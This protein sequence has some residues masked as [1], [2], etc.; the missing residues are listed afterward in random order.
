MLYIIIIIIR[1][2]PYFIHSPTPLHHLHAGLSQ[3]YP[4]A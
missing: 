3:V 4:R 2:D 1:A